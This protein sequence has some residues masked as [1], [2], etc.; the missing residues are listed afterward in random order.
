M[1][2]M[3][4]L[5][6]ALLAR[7]VQLADATP[8]TG[9]ITARCPDKSMG[10]PA[11]GAKLAELCVTCLTDAKKTGCA[12]PKFCPGITG[13]PWCG[14]AKTTQCDT[15]TGTEPASVSLECCQQYV[16]KSVAIQC[17]GKPEC[18][19]VQQSKTVYDKLS[20]AQVTAMCE[21]CFDLGA[22]SG[23]TNTHFCPE[24]TGFPWCADKTMACDALGPDKLTGVTAAM[25]W[26]PEF[27]GRKWVPEV[28][29]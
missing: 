5:A 14:A 22:K 1:Q 19:D 23:C 9:T 10:N 24:E 6:M 2:H 13:E 7:A 28:R 25:G 20:G 29:D 16:N 11:T 18:P 8:V 21:A 3:L 27:G 12:S 4:V 17:G 15:G 26:A